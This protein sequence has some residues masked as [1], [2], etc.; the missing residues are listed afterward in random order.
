[1]WK[2]TRFVPTPAACPHPLLDFLQNIISIPLSDAE[3]TG[4]VALE[5]FKRTISNED[6]SFQHV[7]YS[8]ESAHPY[9]PEL[10]I[11]EKISIPGAANIRITFDARSRTGV[12]TLAFF[13]DEELASE[14]KIFS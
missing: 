5:I 7:L 8:F 1:V 10:T 13:R 6:E 3:L 2:S 9:Q 4:W 12:D 14:L 11:L